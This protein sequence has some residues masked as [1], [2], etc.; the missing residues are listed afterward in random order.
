ML[1]TLMFGSSAGGCKCI[2]MV[3]VGHAA[4]SRVA[5]HLLR[6]TWYV[7]S[8]VNVHLDCFLPPPPEPREPVLPLL[9]KSFVPPTPPPVLD[10]NC[11]VLPLLP[12]SLVPPTLPPAGNKQL[13]WFTLKDHEALRSRTELPARLGAQG[14]DLLLKIIVLD[15]HCWTHRHKDMKMGVM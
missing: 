11:P 12:K 2:F 4:H 6:L 3:N 7:H 5:A 13:Q 1:A 8:G 14:T 9:P 15:A 10:P